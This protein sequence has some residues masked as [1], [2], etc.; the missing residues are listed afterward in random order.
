M[1]NTAHIIHQAVRGLLRDDLD[2]EI[3]IE[4]T[5]IAE[6]GI[7][8]LDFFELLINLE[9]EHGIKIEIDELTPEISAGDIIAL[10]QE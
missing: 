2:P 3:N 1:E 7:D 8:S 4:T 10:A 9:D 5:P 6:L